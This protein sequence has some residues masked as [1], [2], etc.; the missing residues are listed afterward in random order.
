M[1]RAS[2]FRL[3]LLGLILPGFIIYLSDGTITVFFFQ[4][5]F[6]NYIS[7]SGGG[8]GFH[9][10]TTSWFQSNYFGSSLALYLYLASFAL[11][12]LGL[13]VVIGSTYRGGILFFLAGLANLGFMLLFTPVI[14]NIS[15]PLSIFPL[16][17]GAAVLLLTGFI[18]IK[19]MESDKVVSYVR[20]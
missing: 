14:E 6:Y 2:V 17:V 4:G 11:A 1:G 10:L 19:T 5:F 9:W 7:N 8:S 18:G 12:V 3:G 16:P 20:E 15:G 13:I